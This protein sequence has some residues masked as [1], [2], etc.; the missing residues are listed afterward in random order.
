VNYQQIDWLTMESS[1][2]L[3][4]EGSPA[5]TSALQGKEP[6]LQALEAAS[7]G[8]STGSSVRRSRTGSSR[9]TYQPFAVEDWTKFSGA[10]LRSGTM[11]NGTVYPLPPLAPLTAGTES[12]FWPTPTANSSNQCSVDA[13][14]KEAER[15]HP[16]GRWTL[17][18]QVAAMEVHGNPMWPTP[19]ARDW[20][21]ANG[22]D[23]TLNKLQN[24]IRAHLDQLPNAVQMAE[25]KAIRGTLNPTWV[26]WLMGFPLDW[27]DLKPWGTRSSR[28]SQKLSEG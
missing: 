4:A 14:L 7:G 12:G 6:D 27:T 15:L 2:T 13:A 1:L 22:Y 19:A 26:E 9:K 3:S 5:K 21:G 11:R 8:N 24:G 18:S 23:T 10:S 20:K 16:Q 25:G 28:K 17:M